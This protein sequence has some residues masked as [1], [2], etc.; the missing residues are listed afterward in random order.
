M[1][2]EFKNANNLEFYFSFLCPYSYLTWELLKEKLKDTEHH[3][4]P[5]V[6]PMLSDSHRVDS[7]Y[8]NWSDERWLQIA[9]Y[10][11]ELDL[12]IRKPAG[13]LD[14]SVASS[15]VCMEN[16]FLCELIISAVFKGVFN[17]GIDISN[18]QELLDFML[19]NNFTEKLIKNLNYEKDFTCLQEKK[20]QKLEIIKENSIRM[21]PTLKVGNEHFMGL[22]TSEIFDKTIKQR[23]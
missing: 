4:K 20:A 13:K 15:L 3:L 1:E 7:Y 21:L 16:D 18:N 14:C 2:I 5:I 19:E 10:G 22:I 12:T 11:K 6:L 9:N 8:D 17:D 23:L